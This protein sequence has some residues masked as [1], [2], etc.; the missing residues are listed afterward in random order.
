MSALSGVVIDS[1]PIPVYDEFAPDN[2]PTA[3]MIVTNQTDEEVSNKHDFYSTASITVDIVT[4]FAPTLGGKELSERI[5]NAVLMI[6]KPASRT[7]L[8]VPGF[9]V[10]TTRKEQTRGLNEDLSSIRVFR[11]ILIFTHRIKEI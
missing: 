4:T 10:V 6:I 5:A 7:Q 1:V 11:K 9:Q 8:A 2:A 3:Y